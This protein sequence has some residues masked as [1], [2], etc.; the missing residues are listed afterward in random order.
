M[1]TREK[2]RRPA[3][4]PLLRAEVERQLAWAVD[5]RS[6][7]HRDPLW[8]VTE[9]FQQTFDRIGRRRAAQLAAAEP[10]SR[11][12]GDAAP[13]VPDGRRDD[14]GRP[15]QHHPELPQTPIR[16]FSETAFQRGTLA[17]SVLQGT[18]R[19]M[20]ATCLRRAVGQP[21]PLQQ[22]QTL[23]GGGS[24]VR[25]VPGSWPDQAVFHR[26]F[27]ESAVGLVVDV[28]AD[29]RAVVDSMAGLA[30]GEGPV[31]DRDGAAALR[32][33]Y[34]F[35]DDGRER[36]LLEQYRAQLA[37]T[38]DER[39]KPVLQNAIAHTDALIVRK[40]Q[41]KAEFINR[42]RQ[43]SDRAQEAL[44]ELESPETLEYLTAA[45]RPEEAPPPE[46]PPD[47]EGDD[48]GAPEPPPGGERPPDGADAAGGGPP[49]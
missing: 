9:G 28:L 2:K 25:A 35:L 20:L 13:P 14:S 31:T 40:A 32:R 29:A 10:E 38:A 8:H 45:L 12:S 22:R 16:T 21:E 33:V 26:G 48:R 30:R 27:A 4:A 15:A 3:A 6:F 11:R 43:I 37:A 17:A 1:Q 42:L 5:A 18:G 41:M 34:P 19:M 39:E 49:D 24:Q 7:Q 36:M 46:P 44:E 47:G 23:F